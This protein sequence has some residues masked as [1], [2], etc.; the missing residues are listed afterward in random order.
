MKIPMHRFKYT[1]LTSEQIG[2]KLA[3]TVAGPKSFSEY[4][5]IPAGKSLKIVTDNGPVLN[6]RFRK[7]HQL[8]LAVDGGRSVTT[9]YG[10]LTLKQVVFISHM[11]PK[12]Q[13]GYNLIIDQENNLVTVIEVWFSGYQ[14]NREVQRQIYYGYVDKP[15]TDAPKERHHLTNRIEGKGFHWQQDNGIETLEFFPSIISSSFVELTRLGDGLTY[16]S[17]SDFVQLDDNLYAYNRTECEF[18]GIFTMYVLDLFSLEQ[19]GM[20]LGFN[21]MDTLEYYMFRGKGE[22]VGQLAILEPFNEHGE[23]I[24]LGPNRKP[25]GK[26]GERI[27][28][29]PKLSFPYMS[30]DE[31][32][33]AGQ[34]NTSIF[35]DTGNMGGNTLPLSD[36]LVGKELTVRYDDGGPVWEYRFDD[37]KNLRWRNEGEKEWHKEVYHA[38]EADDDLI[39]FGHMHSGTKPAECKKV[40]LDFATGLTTCVNSKMG[41]EYMGNEVS[42]KMT[43]GVIELKGGLEAPRYWRHV[44][45][46]ELTGQAYSWSY[47]DNMTSMHTYSTPHSSSWTIYMGD[48]TLGMQWSAPCQYVKIRNGIYLFSLVEEACNGAQTTVLINTN[49]MHDCGFGFSG[50]QRGLRLGTIGALAR[51]IGVY[52]VKKY[53]GPKVA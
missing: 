4:S 37:T 35:A 20:R 23:T 24:N 30:E 17:P 10:A 38:F 28:Y 50:G 15:G 51:N 47:S 33:Q 52:D 40:V 32:Y 36:L 22:V 19:V 12:T 41:T 53:M 43:F 26:K 27:V 5:G 9:G 49:M 34:K 6:Y 7:N 46:D 18:S 16:C 45:T 42:Y 13:T 29:R 14:D 8:T 3:P 21:E 25:S 44:F 11:V 2:K 39:F 1:K 31:V 48:Q